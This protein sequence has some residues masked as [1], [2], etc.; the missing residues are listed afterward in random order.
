M[1]HDHQDASTPAARVRNRHHAE[2][3][4]DVRG[5]HSIRLEIPPEHDVEV[6]LRYET[7]GQ[8]EEL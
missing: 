1:D 8:P 3:R 4:R 6:V 2:C 5:N 7:G